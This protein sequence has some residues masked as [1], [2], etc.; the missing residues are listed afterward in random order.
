MYGAYY[1]GYAYYGMS[2]GYVFTTFLV[3]DDTAHTHTVETFA[4][5]QEHLLAL[6]DALHAHVVDNVGVALHID[7]AVQDALHL[8]DAEG[9]GQISIL[10]RERPDSPLIKLSLPI[11]QSKRVKPNVTASK[12]RLVLGVDK[13]EIITA[14][15]TQKS[16]LNIKVERVSVDS[17]VDKPSQSV[18][19]NAMLKNVHG[20]KKPLINTV[21]D[22]LVIK[23]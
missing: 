4:L 13:E 17:S 21:D 2:G 1:P 9:A 15:K 6:A 8:H 18:E 12:P 19:N 22:K 16:T 11:V 10:F 7:L 3:V 23:E 5:T 20:T 14:I